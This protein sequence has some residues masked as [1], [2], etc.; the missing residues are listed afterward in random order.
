MTH[1]AT[2]KLKLKM[3]SML[4]RGVGSRSQVG[5]NQVDDKQE[6]DESARQAFCAPW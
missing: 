6:V 1:R 4:L 2:M 5:L 3:K